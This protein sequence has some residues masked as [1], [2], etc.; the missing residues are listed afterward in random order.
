VSVVVPTFNNAVFVADTLDSI[1]AQTFANYELLIA[2]HSSHDGTWDIVSRYG[3]DDRVRLLKTEPGGGAARNW[4]R[5]TAE[6]RGD[7]LKLVCADD[8]L[9]PTCL[10]EQVRAIRRR[11]D[12]A[13]VAGQRDVRDAR[14][15]VLLRGRG[16][17]GLDGEVSGRTAIRASIRAGNNVLG[18]PAC[19]LL[20]TDL[21]NRAGGWSPRAEF[22]ID[23]DLYVRLLA[24][25]SLWAQPTPVAAFRV[26]EGQWSV[27]LVRSQA[28]QMRRFI[29]ETRS[30]HPDI[31][32]ARDARIGKYRAYRNAAGRRAAYVWWSR[33]MRVA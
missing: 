1:L 7:F 8:L 11:P 10:E 9:Y 31:V 12:S 14:G 15:N 5:V 20:R 4:N 23:L 21:V 30:R 6:A 29:E 28:R 32:S 16:L 26:S 25:G 3:T 13:M 2:D 22:L 24:Q 33:R 27:S 19:V 17:A 18:E